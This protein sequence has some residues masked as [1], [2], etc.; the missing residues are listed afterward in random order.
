ARSLAVFATPHSLITFRLPNRLVANVE[1]ADRY[2]IKPLL[3]SVTFPQVGLVL[4]LAQGSVRVVEVA[5]DAGAWEVSVPDMPTDVASAVR[6][7]SITDRAPS[8]RIQGSEGQKVRMR[9][10]ARAIEQALR[11][12]LAGGD[13]PLILASTEPMDSIYRSVNTYPHLAERT[14]PGNPEAA[15][16]EELAA[17]ARIV[18]DEINANTLAEVRVLWGIRSGQGRTLTD[19][20]EVARA[21]THGA[22]DTVLVDI[23]E[24]IAGTID[25][26]TG[27]VTFAPESATNYG[28]IDEIARRVWINSGRVLAVR[29]E[30]IPGD[31]GVAAILRYASF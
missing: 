31:Q 17:S 25:E 26:E 19:V 2:F 16:N 15:S 8:G 29:H 3:R 24:Q 22:V 30:D 21:A 5:A 23:D 18:L 7:A 6:K 9:Q 12:T 4:A 10:Y 14:I 27:A 11:Q 1:V 28:V 13:V 20:V